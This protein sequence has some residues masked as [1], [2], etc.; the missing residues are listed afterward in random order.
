MINPIQNTLIPPIAS[1]K[2]W[3]DPHY[4][5]FDQAHFNFYYE[6]QFTLARDLPGNFAVYTFLNQCAAG[7]FS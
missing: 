1:C 5:T 3:G 2:G 4:T 6:G 7:R